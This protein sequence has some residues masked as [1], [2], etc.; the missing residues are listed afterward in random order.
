MG[1]KNKLNDTAGVSSNYLFA[2]NPRLERDE[3][4][5][6]SHMIFHQAAPEAAPVAAEVEITAG[7]NV[8]FFLF[9]CEPADVCF[10]W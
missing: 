5:E 8:F 10:F 2:F 9:F 4:S 1:E 7:G 6:R 3:G